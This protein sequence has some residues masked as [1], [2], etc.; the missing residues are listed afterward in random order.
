MRETTSKATPCQP[1]NIKM[2]QYYKVIVS[3]PET[4]WYSVNHVSKPHSAMRLKDKQKY[5]MQ[6]TSRVFN[7]CPLYIR[8]LYS[9]D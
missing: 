4:E 6:M 2:K 1:I 8:Q 3:L 7:I 5:I 9:L